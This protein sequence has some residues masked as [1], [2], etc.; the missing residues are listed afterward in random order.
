[1]KGQLQRFIR[2]LSNLYFRFNN[3]NHWDQ[4]YLYRKNLERG[5]SF[6]S[7]NLP[8]PVIEKYKKSLNW[9]N[10]FFYKYPHRC[11]VEPSLGYAVTGRVLIK[12][13]L[14]H[15]YVHPRLSKPNC[16]RYI[17]NTK[18]FSKIKIERAIVLQ[19]GASNYWHF[20][21]DFLGALRLAEELK[22]DNQIPVLVPES[23]RKQTFFKQILSSAPELQKKK[24][25]FQ[26]KNEYYE[27]GETYF[28]VT[29]HAHRKNF[30][31]ALKNIVIPEKGKDSTASSEKIFV[32]RNAK[33]GRTIQNLQEIE[34]IAES[35]DFK[36]INCDLLSLH[37]Q[38]NCF[39]RAKL[40]IGIHG[41][42]L[43]N[44]IYCKKILALLEIMPSSRISPVYYLMAK[45]YGYSY[46]C[47]LGQGQDEHKNFVI[48]SRDFLQKIIIFIDG[49]TTN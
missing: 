7:F 35:F 33:W 32:T 21:N 38:I 20:Y 27:V 6:N 8:S 45:H 43:T 18:L 47:L 40:C 41:A 19:F 23:L 5:F 10:E 15:R 16:I 49:E 24:W 29:A 39:R 2:Y 4:F 37:Q 46:D 14:W 11:I 28:L 12:E 13:S 30:N 44:I 9:T 3:D 48:E 17:L 22:I 42:G 1:M 31:Y 34:S 26:K 36:I 25:V